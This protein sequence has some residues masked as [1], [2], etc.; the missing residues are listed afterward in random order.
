M[1]LGNVKGG[2]VIELK[3]PRSELERGRGLEGSLWL[4]FILKKPF[5]CSVCGL[6]AVGHEGGVVTT[7]LPHS[8]LKCPRSLRAAKGGNKART[9]GR[10]SRLSPPPCSENKALLPQPAGGSQTGG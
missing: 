8:S 5:N 3:L 1:S 9:K 7:Q 6:K 2:G 10:Q 4:G